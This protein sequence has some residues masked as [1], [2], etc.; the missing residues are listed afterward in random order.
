MRMNDC[1]IIDH[2]RKRPIMS[3]ILN[4]GATTFMWGCWAWILR[5]HPFLNFR[6]FL[7]TLPHYVKE[8]IVA[9]VST[10]SF[11]M[12]WNLFEVDLPSIQKVNPSDYAKS[13]NLTE[14]EL[15]E[16]MNAK[17]CTIHHNNSGNIVKIEKQLCL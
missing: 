8:P 3:R 15:I 14:Q 5:F 2:S 9:L 17:I 4:D 7:V 13:F 1:I 11:L 16:C 10:S 6:I 12:I